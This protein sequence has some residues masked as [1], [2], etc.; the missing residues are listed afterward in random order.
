MADR[1]SVNSTGS[2]TGPVSK[3]SG[4]LDERPGGPHANLA[5]EAAA[6]RTT[7]DT[8]QTTGSRQE[9][10]GVDE[11]EERG[12]WTGRFDFLLSMLG[13]AVGLG[14]VWRFPYLCYRNGGGAFLIPFAIMMCIVGVPLFFLESCIGQF[15]SRGPMTCWGFAPLLKGVGISMVL[16]SAMTALYYNMVLAWA[17]YYMFASFTSKL[18]WSECDKKLMKANEW[19]SGIV[20]S[21]A[22]NDSVTVKAPNGTCWDSKGGLLGVYD[23][24]LLKTIAG[25]YRRSPAEIYWNNVALDLSPGI[26]TFGQPKWYLALC[27][28]VAWIVVFLCLIKG[29]KSTGKVVY[30]TA[31]FPYVVLTILFFRGVTLENAGEGVKFFI[32]P[33]WSRLLDARVWKDAAVQVF[34][35]LSVAGGGLVTLS[36][37][38]RFHNNILKDCVIVVVGDF[39]TSIFAGFVIF[40]YIGFMAGKQ[41]TTVDKVAQEGAGLAF[42][43]YPDAVTN[44]P[45][46]PFWSIL[47]FFMLITL[48]LDSQFAMVETV[49]TGCLDQF[50]VL[51]PKKTLVILVVCFVFFLFGLPLTCPGGVYLLQIMD[52]FV[53]GWTLLIIGLAENIA[54]AY[55]YGVPR[56]CKDLEVMLGYK[57]NIIWKIF[58]YAVSPIAVMFIFVFTFVDYQASTYG[59]YRF[60]GWADA[61]GWLMAVFVISPIFITIFYK[62]WKEDDEDSFIK[63]VKTLMMPT[64]EWGPY[65]V[66][67]RKLIEDEGYVA[68]FVVDPYAEKEANEGSSQR[69]FTLSS[70][71]INSTISRGT[72]KGSLSSI[73][74][75]N[76]NGTGKYGNGSVASQPSIK[77][78]ESNV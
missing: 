9:L 10:Y 63:K 13:Y 51:R 46:P 31:L 64:R 73:A 20:A 54:V 78:I 15:S 45:A 2:E 24:T 49:L 33:V 38:N 40:S 5:F 29:I 72:S 25:I 77:S 19:C 18:P 30:F 71:S 55:F 69:H 53:G 8:Q 11:N 6:S 41:G 74:R 7:L 22:C 34:F 26:G 42:V 32:V 62:I 44:L 59:D 61:I 60:P 56:F 17:F 23:D 66:K 70:L 65:L 76:R 35:S 47:F 36:S 48:G 14:N 12:N 57:Q 16:V 67:H 39:F 58:W 37:Y 4:T 3:I 27:L 1:Y 43:V 50:P 68:G 52:N 21:V 75:P 28:L